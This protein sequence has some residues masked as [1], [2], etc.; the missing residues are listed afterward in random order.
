MTIFEFEKIASLFNKRKVRI[1]QYLESWMQQ[2][3]IAHLDEEDFRDA[4]SVA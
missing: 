1:K 4:R 3:L 2:G